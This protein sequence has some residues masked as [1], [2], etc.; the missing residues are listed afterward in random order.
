MNI[1]RKHTMV[2]N[3]TISKQKMQSPKYIP[4]PEILQEYILFNNNAGQ[5]FAEGPKIRQLYKEYVNTIY[6]TSEACRIAISSNS[7]EEALDIMEASPHIIY[8]RY[9]ST[10]INPRAIKLLSYNI[11]KICWEEL[12]A[13]PN[14]AA[15]ALV[16]LHKKKDGGVCWCNKRKKINYQR[17]CCCTLNYNS[18]AKREDFDIYI[19]NYHSSQLSFNSSDDALD[20][21]ELNPD[22]IYW[23]SMSRNTNPRAI[24]LLIKHNH[25]HIL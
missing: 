1:L 21:L 11:K 14:P 20:Y 12:A 13:N 7:S 6:D 4:K 8:W 2:S 25:S 19:N 3:K 23:H 15:L 18:A 10:N 5:F 22:L 9:F 24:K 16:K 17:Y